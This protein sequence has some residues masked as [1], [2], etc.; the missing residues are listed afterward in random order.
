MVIKVRNLIKTEYMLDSWIWNMHMPNF[1]RYHYF[2]ELYDEKVRLHSL[3]ETSGSSAHGRKN[4]I[5][6]ILKKF[7]V[8]RIPYYNK[9]KILIKK[10]DFNWPDLTS[11]KSQFWWRH[12][13]NW[14]WLSIPTCKLT[15][16]ACVARHTCDPNFQPP[17]V[18]WPW[19]W[20]LLVRTGTQAVPVLGI[21]QHFGRVWTL[22]GPS[23][24]P[25]CKMWNDASWPLIWP[26]PL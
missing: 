26:W 20:P 24:R 3:L 10:Y 7:R 9:K 15:Q 19:P 11:V 2:T 21:Y 14:S 23:Y 17:F 22:C 25:E 1:N 5:F 6:E 16:K 12:R 4:V 8:R 18:A 13:V